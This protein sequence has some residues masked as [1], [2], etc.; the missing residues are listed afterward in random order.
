MPE[1]GWSGGMLLRRSERCCPDAVLGLCRPAACYERGHKA[2][3][4]TLVVCMS[5]SGS[6]ITLDQDRLRIP[7]RSLSLKF[8]QPRDLHPKSSRGATQA[9]NGP[10]PPNATLQTDLKHR[11]SKL[12][13]S[14]HLEELSKS[15]N[16]NFRGR[17]PGRKN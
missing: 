16:Y 14:Y 7:L 4:C 8:G 6:D 12:Q 11:C 1:L 3:V 13:G 17:S 15:C 2:E 9:P 10:K 5:D